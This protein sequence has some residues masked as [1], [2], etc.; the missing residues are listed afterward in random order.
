MYCMNCG[1]QLPEEAGFCLKC[2][3]RQGQDQRS[4]SLPGESTKNTES[5]HKIEML[6]AYSDYAGARTMCNSLLAQDPSDGTA[7]F[8][9]LMADLQCRYKIELETKGNYFDNINYLKA[10]MFGDDSLKTELQK[11]QAAARLL[12]K[13]EN[14]RDDAD[15]RARLRDVRAGD[16]IN[17]GYLGGEPIQW[18][19]LKV[20]SYEDGHKDL[21]LISKNAVTQMPYDQSE[22]ETSWEKCT[23]RKWLNNDFLDNS[24]SLA[25]K[26]RM[27]VTTMVA[28]S[29][30]DFGVP[31]GNPTG[32]RV[33][34]QSWREIQFADSFPDNASRSI[35][36]DWWLRSPGSCADAAAYINYEGSISSYGKPVQ[37]VCGV[38]PSLFLRI[39]P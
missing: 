29:N 2:G 31:A 20:F 24:F 39:A 9:L 32:D 30:P 26:A 25:E 38:R 7:Y 18:L 10:M 14:Q 23:L 16:I 17:L 36:S 6:L 22:G 11:Y 8:Y 33:F 15:L 13:P 27:I 3:A 35:G 12:T 1:Q 21:F 37:S 19:V 34:L 28:E 4:G 5:L